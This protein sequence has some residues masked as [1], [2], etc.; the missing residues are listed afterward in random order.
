MKTTDLRRH[1]GNSHGH[2][3]EECVRNAL[4]TRRQDKQVETGQETEH[5]TLEAEKIHVDCQYMGGGFGSKFG[6]DRWVQM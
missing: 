1:G 2:G 3:F 5:I 6:A 4:R